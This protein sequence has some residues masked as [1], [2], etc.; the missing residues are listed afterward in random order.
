MAQIYIDIHTHQ[1]SLLGTD[2]FSVYNNTLNSLQDYSFSAPTS[3]GLHPWHISE[4][5]PFHGI[6]ILKELLQENKILAVGECGLD[7][8]ISLPLTIQQAVFQKQIKL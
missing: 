7:K 5:T 8:V 2:L 6:S 1:H 4:D 3:A